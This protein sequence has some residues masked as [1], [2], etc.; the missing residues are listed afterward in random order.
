MDCVLRARRL[1][2]SFGGGDGESRVIAHLSARGGGQSSSPVSGKGS[3][4]MSPDRGKG[5]DSTADVS[6][7]EESE[8]LNRHGERESE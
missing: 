7:G 5:E 4:D 6:K 8:K 2:R 1:Q 3:Q